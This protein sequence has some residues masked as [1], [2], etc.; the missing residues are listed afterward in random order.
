MIV[1]IVRRKLIIALQLNIIMV[2]TTKKRIIDLLTLEIFHVA[3][4]IVL[5]G[6][7]SWILFRLSDFRF[8]NFNII[9]VNTHLSVMRAE[10]RWN[11]N[12][13]VMGH[14]L[15]GGALSFMSFIQS[16]FTNS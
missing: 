6:K 16:L 14:S 7:L 10:M 5:P 13:G 8:A 15:S 12:Y 2:W 4:K 9:E 3:W 1:L 11:S